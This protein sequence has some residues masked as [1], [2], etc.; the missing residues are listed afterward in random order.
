MAFLLLHNYTDF[1]N[2]IAN[3]DKNNYIPENGNVFFI[4]NNFLNFY[5]N[6]NHDFKMINKNS[7]KINEFIPPRLQH[8]KSLIQ[9]NHQRCMNY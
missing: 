8:Q 5:K 6:I 4:N 3:P 1:I 2:N 7:D 9:K